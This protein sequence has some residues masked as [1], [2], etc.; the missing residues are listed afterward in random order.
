[1]YGNHLPQRLAAIFV[2]LACLAGFTAAPAPAQTVGTWTTMP[3]PAATAS[4]TCP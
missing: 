2:A 1:M 3:H 4:W